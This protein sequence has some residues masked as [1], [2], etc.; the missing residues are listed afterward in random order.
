MST[1]RFPGAARIKES[2][3]PQLEKKNFCGVLIYLLMVF[4]DEMHIQKAKR[5]GEQFSISNLEMKY[6]KRWI[7]NFKKRHNTKEMTICRESGSVNKIDASKEREN[8]QNFLSVY[9]PEEIYNFDECA[10]FYR[11]HPSKTLA[12]SSKSFL[13]KQDKQRI[14]IGICNNATGKDKVKSLVI[15]KCCRPRCFGKVWCPSSLVYYSYNKKAWM[16]GDLFKKWLEWFES[17]IK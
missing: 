4:N 11:L 15:G 14:T 13:T 16:T 12:S 8:L 10:L 2:K 3:F 1:Y 5:F 7:H 6:S 9:K 17:R